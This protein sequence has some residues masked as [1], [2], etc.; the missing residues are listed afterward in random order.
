MVIDAPLGV[1][2]IKNLNK[3]GKIDLT[4]SKCRKKNGSNGSNIFVKLL[5]Y[6]TKQ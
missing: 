4:Q 1:P 3:M 2:T 6:K 5:S